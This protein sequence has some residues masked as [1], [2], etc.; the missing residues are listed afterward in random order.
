L[1]LENDRADLIDSLRH[2]R[3]E[4]DGARRR[5]EA[6]NRAKSEFLANMSHELRTPL[7]AII[8]FSD[9]I[10]TRAV[11]PTHDKYA[12]YASFINESGNHLLALISGV[13]ELANI[14]AG[15][16][17]LNEED[18]NIAVAVRDAVEDVRA[19][20]RDREV[21]VEVVQSGA[22]PKLLADRHAVHEILYQLLSNAVKFTQPDGYVSVGAQI[23]AQSGELALV[24]ADTGI[25]IDPDEQAQAFDRFGRGKHDV[26][27]ANAGAGLGLPIVKGLAELHGGR[28]S[29]LSAP[30]EGTRI[31]VYF[32][33]SRISAPP[34]RAVV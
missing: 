27:R 23:S 20:A 28:V 31:T 25:G 17:A 5:A 15:R 12:E 16:K 19:V 26:A 3:D 8:G 11:G 14:E 29:L 7:N 13:L 9:I 34:L 22:V 24:V 30:G 4:S 18:V 10:R 2:A 6:A 1:R 33:A 21:T 32:P